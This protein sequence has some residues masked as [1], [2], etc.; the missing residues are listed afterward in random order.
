M[1]KRFGS[2]RLSPYLCSMQTKEQRKVVQ[3]KYYEAHREHLR[4][5]ARMTGSNSRTRKRA[6]IREYLNIHP[7]VDCG[8]SDIRV[9][10]FD[11]VRGTKIMHVALM[12]GRNMKLDVIIS[13]IAKCDVRCANCHRIVTQERRNNQ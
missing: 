10:E 2:F 11:H 8:N 7:C 3:A 9:L 5:K 1:S 12:V 6:F 4:E 13:E